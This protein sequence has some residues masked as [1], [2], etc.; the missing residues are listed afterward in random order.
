MHDDEKYPFH[1][2]VL[3]LD[4]L[5]DDYPTAPSAETQQYA[6]DDIEAQFVALMAQAR[7]DPDPWKAIKIIINLEKML[8]SYTSEGFDMIVPFQAA[9]QS[10]LRNVWRA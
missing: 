8:D 1:Y 2:A 10:D 9:V 3:P 7:Q 4:P 5:P 6:I